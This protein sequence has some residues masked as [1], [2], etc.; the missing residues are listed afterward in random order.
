MP[1][2]ARDWVFTYDLCCIPTEFDNVL[3]TN[4]MYALAGMNN[5]DFPDSLAKNFSPVWHTR[6]PNIP[7]HIG[8]TLI[9]YPIRTTCEYRKYVIDQATKEYNGDRV[10]YELRNPGYIAPYSLV[11]PLP[12]D[13]PPA[14]TIDS[15]LGRIF[16]NPIR[17]DTT[18]GSLQL[19]MI[20]IK[21][22]EYRIDTDLVSGNYVPKEK[23]IGFVRRTLIL[24]PSDSGTC[25]DELIE[26]ADTSKYHYPSS[27]Q[28][29]ECAGNTMT[30]ALTIP[31]LCSSIDTNASNL[32]MLHALTGDT[33]NILRSN[34]QNC[35]YYRNTKTFVIEFDARPTPGNYL[36]VLIK[37]D[38]GNTLITDCMLELQPFADTLY[39]EVED[40]LKDGA[41]IG[42][43]INGQRDTIFMTCGSGGLTTY[44]TKPGNCTSVQSNGSDFLLINTAFPVPDTLGIY[45]AVAQNCN[46]ANNTTMVFIGINPR[47]DPGLYRLYLVTGSDGN[48]ITNVCNSSWDTS[49]VLV[50][51]REIELNIGSDFTYCKNSGFD[52]ILTAGMEFV[53]Y[54]WNT[55]HTG[56]YI[57]IDTAGTYWVRVE[58]IRG[59]VT[60]DTIHISEEDCYIGTDEHLSNQPVIV[61]PNP[62]GER[63]SILNLPEEQMAYELLDC[64]ARKI[65]Q[66]EL[67]SGENRIE[68]HGIDSGLYTLFIRSREGLFHSARIQVQ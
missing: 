41:I 14:F 35:T 50:K 24:T 16:Y 56:L 39:I 64:S 7:G 17:P 40:P 60:T 18:Y 66:G 10:K 26:F 51:V 9:N 65:L 58:D 53:S 57:T 5:K 67:K 34:P 36:L 19:Y 23:V 30:V 59:C 55:G 15:A 21:A 29:L 38:D 6:R 13:S 68:L 12:H 2:K 20:D 27:G 43:T 49:M 37:G 32:L 63:V 11:K 44:L 28:T 31:V 62:A 52:T 33:I 46:F 54:L 1:K 25:P 42:D 48:S 8:D 3:T 61:V 22:T 45:H 47:P 4:T